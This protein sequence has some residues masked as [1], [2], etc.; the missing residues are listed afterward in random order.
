MSVHAHL[1]RAI[2]RKYKTIYPAL[3]VSNGIITP[4][5]SNSHVFE[6]VFYNY[7][8]STSYHCYGLYQDRHLNFI[9]M[10]KD[11]IRYGD[12]K[13]TDHLFS[14]H[15]NLRVSYALVTNSIATK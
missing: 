8:N 2:I 13:N 9:S 4:N 11:E 15:K 5:D 7:K 12:K 10:V 3:N 14:L 6:H 1:Y